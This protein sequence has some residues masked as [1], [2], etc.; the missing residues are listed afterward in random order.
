MLWFSCRSVKPRCLQ[1]VFRPVCQALQG[2]PFPTEPCVSCQEVLTGSQA[3]AW[4]MWQNKNSK[5]RYMNNGP[6]KKLPQT[7][8]NWPEQWCSLTPEIHHSCHE[9]RDRKDTKKKSLGKWFIRG[10]HT[11]KFSSL[12]AISAKIS[13]DHSYFWTAPKAMQLSFYPEY[14]IYL[15]GKFCS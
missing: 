13:A 2:S 15:W 9:S 11:S 10:H 5:D 4:T 14:S 8:Q 7:S 6:S 1:A 12:V 3:T